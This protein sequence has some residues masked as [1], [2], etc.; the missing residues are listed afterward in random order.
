MYKFVI[1]SALLYTAMTSHTMA[2]APE[3]GHHRWLNQVSGGEAQEGDNIEN[4]NGIDENGGKLSFADTTSSRSGSSSGSG[5][6]VHI[7]GN[8]NPTAQPRSSG[9][10]TTTI[11]TTTSTVA[12]AVT[13]AAMII[14]L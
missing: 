5:I 7:I 12:I 14:Y 1:F 11:S 9:S 10:I 2:S 3:P 8:I 13:S 6:D 4:G